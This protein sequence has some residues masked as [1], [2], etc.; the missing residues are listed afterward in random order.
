MGFPQ[1]LRIGLHHRAQGRGVTLIFP[2]APRQTR[3]YERGQI[4]EQSE[5]GRERR[6]LM[7]YLRSNADSKRVLDLCTGVPCSDRS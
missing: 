5:A 3:V 6:P 7:L 1:H 2:Q 4:A